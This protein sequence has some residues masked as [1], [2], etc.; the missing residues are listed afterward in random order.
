MEWKNIKTNTKPKQADEEVKQNASSEK[1][2]NENT[3]L[4]EVSS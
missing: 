3:L 2:P 1:V 4:K